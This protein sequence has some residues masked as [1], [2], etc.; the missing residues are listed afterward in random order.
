M[1]YELRIYRFHP[2]T[3]KVFLANFKKALP[4]SAL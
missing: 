3:K 4:D 1:I 2:G